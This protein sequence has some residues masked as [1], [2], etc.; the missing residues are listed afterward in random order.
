MKV[1]HGMAIKLAI[2]A[3]HATKPKKAAFSG[4]VSRD[5]PN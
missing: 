5:K 3:I 4:K 2:G 1:I